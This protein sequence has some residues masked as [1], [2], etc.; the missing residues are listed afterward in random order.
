MIDHIV[1]W[2]LPIPDKDSNSSYLDITKDGDN[3]VLV[4]AIETKVV[5]DN[6]AVAGISISKEDVKEII[7]KLCS[8]V[9]LT[10]AT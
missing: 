1:L 7:S 10:H 4:N 9:E 3:F 2:N 8:L 5:K 6:M